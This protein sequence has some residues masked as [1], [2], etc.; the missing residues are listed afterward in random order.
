[1]TGVRMSIDIIEEP[2]SALPEHAAIPI[3][4]RVDRILDVIPSVE[5]FGTVER[6]LDAA[7]I[8]DYD[9]SR[10]GADTEWQ[11]TVRRMRPGRPCVSHEHSRSRTLS[12]LSGRRSS[13]LIGARHPDILLPGP[14]E[15]R[16]GCM[17]SVPVVVLRR[18]RCTSVSVGPA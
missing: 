15:S 8:K 5:G 13:P 6:P 1:M 12:L 4:F 14:S 3:A 2:M 9:R 16:E 10:R 7:Y 18:L 17:S 11:L